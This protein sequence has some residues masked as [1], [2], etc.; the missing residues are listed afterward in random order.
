M[1]LICAHNGLR[2]LP[3]IM[4]GRL[5]AMILLCGGLPP[6]PL[7]KAVRG[8]RSAMA[9]ADEGLSNIQYKF[10]GHCHF[11]AKDIAAIARHD[12]GE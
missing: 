3:P 2:C 5:S 8:H 6:P 9:L 10:A 11:N 7:A 1:V 12:L 4:A